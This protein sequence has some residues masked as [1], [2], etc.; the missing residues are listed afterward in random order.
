MEVAGLL[1]LAVLSGIL[2]TLRDEAPSIGHDEA[3]AGSMGRSFRLTATRLAPVRSLRLYAPA[4]TGDW[5]PAY[6]VT[7]DLKNEMIRPKIVE[8]IK[9]G[10][11]WAQLSGSSYAI[12]TRETPQAIYMKLSA[13]LSGSA[14]LYVIALNRPYYGQGMKDVNHW[15]TQCF[16]K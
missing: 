14:T 8:A 7:Y 1:A 4:K 13:F 12:S 11:S 3:H 9:K 10:R 6:I 15:L 16:P 5:M 2:D